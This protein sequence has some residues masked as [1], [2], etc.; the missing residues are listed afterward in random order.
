MLSPRG[1]FLLLLLLVFDFGVHRSTA[2]MFP[3]GDVSPTHFK[4]PDP[5]PHA[6]PEARSRETRR[7]QIQEPTHAM[8]AVLQRQRKAFDSAAAITDT[9]PRSHLASGHVARAAETM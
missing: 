5:C 2:A 4:P 7:D 9:L 1:C 8:Q 3:T 6:P